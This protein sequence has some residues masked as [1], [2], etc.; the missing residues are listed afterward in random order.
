M[1]LL[2]AIFFFASLVAGRAQTVANTHNVLHPLTKLGPNG[3]TS[4][5][6]D[7]SLANEYR[8]T[9]TRAI[10]TYYPNPSAQPA[11]PT[12]IVAK[13]DP[14]FSASKVSVIGAIA[15][16]KG[17]LYVTNIGDKV[18]TPH[19]QLAVCNLKGFPIGSAIKDGQPLAPNESE[20]IDVLAT[21]ADAVDLK[22]LRLT[23][24]H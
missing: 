13:V 9:S 18:A 16:L 8:N 22:L 2:V 20:K 7:P 15:G 14:S 5:K 11:I 23:A 4:L 19:I 10:P 3:L 6:Q 1:K 12:E 24:A 17:S 21:N